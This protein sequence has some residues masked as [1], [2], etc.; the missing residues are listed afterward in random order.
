MRPN[1]LAF[2]IQLVQQNQ[3]ASPIEGGLD[4]N[5]A[6][7]INEVD[8]PKAPTPTDVGTL[9][10][11]I[12]RMAIGMDET[13]KSAY[14]KL[15]LDSEE[16]KGI[17]SYIESMF[18]KDFLDERIKDN[19]QDIDLNMARIKRFD[20][21]AGPV[22]LLGKT[23]QYLEEDLPMIL[24]S[25]F[26]LLGTTLASAAVGTMMAP[27]VGTV[28]GLAVGAAGMAASRYVESLAEAGGAYQEAFGKFKAMK[29][30]GHPDFVN[31]SEDEM[32]QKAMTASD[33]VFKDN[34]KLMAMDVPMLLLA[35]API[36]KVAAR[37]TG[38]GRGTY[39][40]NSIGAQIA[41]KSAYMAARYP[42]INALR[43]L[44]ISTG[45][46]AEEGVQ[47]GIT[48]SAIAK[49]TGSRAMKLDEMF[50][51]E[52][53]VKSLIGGF[54]VGG[55][56]SGIGTLGGKIKEAMIGKEDN[57]AAFDIN[58]LK[59]VQED[60]NDAQLLSMYNFW[61]R[62]KVSSMWGTLQAT[63]ER[64]QF[65]DKKAVDQ[66]AETKYHVERIKTLK[67]N[68]DE[69]MT[70]YQATIDAFPSLQKDIETTDPTTG[71]KINK[72]N[73]LRKQVFLLTAKLHGIETDLKEVSKSAIKNNDYVAFYTDM[74]K[75][76]TAV[77]QKMIN[78]EDVSKELEILEKAETKFLENGLQLKE[79]AKASPSGAAQTEV[80]P[81][82]QMA[83][84]PMPEE[85]TEKIDKT[86]ETVPGTDKTDPLYNEEVHKLLAQAG[87][88]EEPASETE[89]EKE[90][91]RL[92]KIKNTSKELAEELNVNQTS[93]LDS[94]GQAY[95]LNDDDVTPQVALSGDPD[96]TITEIN[97]RNL[98]PIK[99]NDGDNV[100][101]SDYTGEFMPEN[102]KGDSI[103]IKNGVLYQPDGEFQTDSYAGRQ[104]R[105]KTV[106][107]KEF[108][109]KDGNRYMVGFQTPYSSK[110]KNKGRTMQGSGY[111]I[112]VK[113][114]GSI[115][116]DNV[117]MMYRTIDE[118]SA[119]DNFL[120]YSAWPKL[121]DKLG[122]TPVEDT[123][124][125]KAIKEDATKKQSTDVKDNEK[126]NEE[127]GQVL[128][129]PEAKVDSKESAE[130][131]EK[132]RKVK[133]PELDLKVE[134][135]GSYKV[136]PKDDSSFDLVGP[137]GLVKNYKKRGAA[138][139]AAD[140]LNKTQIKK[141][142]GVAKTPETKKEE[143]KKEEPKKEE[144]SDFV[145]EFNK[146]EASQKHGILSREISLKGGKMKGVIR[147]T[148]GQFN[149]WGMNFGTLSKVNAYFKTNGR[150]P[151]VLNHGNGFIEKG[152][153]LKIE[154]LQN[155]DGSF[156]NIPEGWEYRLQADGTYNLYDGKRI[157]I[158][159][160]D[161][162]GNTQFKAGVHNSY[163]VEL[164]DGRFVNLVPE[165]YSELTKDDD[166]AEVEL[167][168]SFPHKGDPNVVTV[169][170]TDVFLYGNALYM[171][172]IDV[173][174]DG[175]KVSRVF[176]SEKIE[177]SQR[178]DAEAEKNK[179][180]DWLNRNIDMLANIRKTVAKDALLGI[181]LGIAEVVLKAFRVIY[182]K[183]N[184]QERFSPNVGD[185][186]YKKMGYIGKEDSSI[187]LNVNDP[188][189]IQQFVNA[190]NRFKEMQKGVV[191]N[192]PEIVH[193][194][195]ANSGSEAE[196][197]DA[198]TKRMK[199]AQRP[200][201]AEE[202][203][204]Y[205]VL[206][207]EKPVK[208]RIND[209]AKEKV[210]ENLTK[211]EADAALKAWLGK[212]NAWIESV[213][214]R[215]KETLQSQKGAGGLLKTLNTEEAFL[216]E[217]YE[218]LDNEAKLRKFQIENNM[219][220]LA[221]RV[222]VFFKIPGVHES[223]VREELSDYAKKMPSER[224]SPDKFKEYYTSDKAELS[225]D[226]KNY[227][228]SM[229]LPARYYVSLHA[230]LQSWNKEEFIYMTT[231]DSSV[232]L[233]SLVGN[234]LSKQSVVKK[235]LI[236][237]LKE[238]VENA[239]LNKE[240]KEQTRFEDWNAMLKRNKEMAS[241]ARVIMAKKIS[242]VP[243]VKEI[244]APY[245][246]AD[247]S[248]NGLV[249]S[250]YTKVQKEAMNI[251]ASMSQESIT[252]I[253]NQYKAY[254]EALSLIN[255]DLNV[256]RSIMK[257]MM[258]N[259]MKYFEIHTG[260]SK[261]ELMASAVSAHNSLKNGK[262]AKE[263]IITIDNTVDPV[264]ESSLVFL[265]Q[266]DKSRD[267]SIFL[268]RAVQDYN[269]TK[270]K[271]E[272]LPGY[273][274]YLLTEKGRKSAYSNFSVSLVSKVATGVT[275][276]E[277]MILAERF[278][279]VNGTKA[280]G[281]KLDNLFRR[282]SKLVPG[283]SS[284][285]KFSKNGFVQ[286]HK[287]KAPVV[288]W[289]DGLRYYDETKGLGNFT[290]EEL[291][292]TFVSMYLNR[293]TDSGIYLHPI[294]ILGDRTNQMA[295]VET[296]SYSLATAKEIAGPDVEREWKKSKDEIMR[297]LNSNAH[298]LN[299]P[300]D[301]ML[302]QIAEEFFYNYAV[303]KMD[304]DAVYQGDQSI[305]KGYPNKTK[306]A[307]QKASTG[308]NPVLNITDGMPTTSR[309]L[310]L[311]D[312]AGTY[313][314]L[315]KEYSVSEVAN[316]T[317]YISERYNKQI[318]VST[319]DLFHFDGTVK[320][321]INEY[322]P[323]SGNALL[324]KSN[325]I[326]L[327][328]E[329]VE[330]AGGDKSPLAAIYKQLNDPK[331]PIDLISFTSNAKVR[332]TSKDLT[333][334]DLNGPKVTNAVHNVDSSGIIFQQDLRF[335]QDPS[336][337][338]FQ[339]G[340]FP[341]QVYRY[342]MQFP[343]FE[344]MHNAFLQQQYEGFAQASKEILAAR[345]VP[346]LFIHFVLKQLKNSPEDM[347]IR[348]VL[349]SSENITP[350]VELNLE[351]DTLEDI[352]A[353][354]STSFVSKRDFAIGEKI[355]LKNSEFE[356]LT[357]ALGVLVEIVDS[358]KTSD[359]KTDYSV[360]VIDNL[361]TR[362]SRG[363]N[364][365]KFN[366]PVVRDRMMGL[367]G[368][369]VANKAVQRKVNR[370]AL[371][372]VSS[373]GIIG[374]KSLK[375]ARIETI[376]GKKVL[377]PGQALVPEKL[378]N[379]LIEKNGKKYLFIIR[380]PTTEMHSVSLV[381]VVGFLPNAMHNSIITD[382]A[383]QIKAGSDN[384]GDQRFAI[385][386][387]KGKKLTT[388]QENSNLVVESMLQIF[389]NPN[390]R[391]SLDTPIDLE[392][393]KAMADK[394]NPSKED[395]LNQNNVLSAIKMW[396]NNA[397]A[398]KA[399]GIA[400]RTLG[401]YQLLKKWDA[402]VKS[403]ISVNGVWLKSFKQANP[404]IQ[405]EI[406]SELANIT[407]IIVDNAKETK[408]RQIGLSQTTTNMY[409]AL[410]ML[411]MPADQL[412]YL[413]TQTE[414]GKQLFS[415]LQESKNILKEGSQYSVFKSIL[416]KYAVEG[417]DF[418]NMSIAKISKSS[419]SEQVALLKFAF[420]LSNEMYRY[421]EMMKVNEDGILNETDYINAISV[422]SKLKK[423][424]FDEKSRDLIL[425]KNDQHPIVSNLM[426]PFR[427]ALDAAHKTYSQSIYDTAPANML[428]DLMVNKYGYTDTKKVLRTFNRVAISTAFGIT[429]KNSMS[430]VE[431]SKFYDQHILDTP[432]SEYLKFNGKIEL[433]PGISIVDISDAQISDMANLIS[434]LPENVQEALLK[435]HI[436]EYGFSF[437]AGFTKAFP[438][439]LQNQ[440]ALKMSELQ[441]AWKQVD[442]RTSLSVIKEIARIIPD[443]IGM[444]IKDEEKL[445]T[446]ISKQV[447]L[448]K[449]PLVLIS[450]NKSIYV[451]KQ[452]VLGKAVT[453]ELISRNKKGDTFVSGVENRRKERPEF[454]RLP[455]YN[456]NAKTMTFAG[457]G[458]RQ[459]PQSMKPLVDKAIAMIKES[460][461]Y[462]LR[463][464]GAIGADTIFENAWGSDKKEIFLTKNY[465]EKTNPREFAIM[466]EI[467]PK[468]QSL[469][470][471]GPAKQ[472]RNTNQIFGAKLDTPVDFVLCWTQDGAVNADQTTTVTGGTGQAI[473]MASMKGIPVI[474]MLNPSWMIELE[475]VLSNRFIAQP[476]ANVK[477]QAELDAEKVIGLVS[478]DNRSFGRLK[479]KMMIFPSDDFYVGKGI[480][481]SK[482]GELY[483][484]AKASISIFNGNPPSPNSLLNMG[485]ESLE[486]FL[487]AEPRAKAAI[488]SKSDLPIYKVVRRGSIGTS[489]PEQMETPVKKAPITDGFKIYSSLINELEMVP[490]QEEKFFVWNG[491][492]F[493]QKNKYDII[494]VVPFGK[495]GI[496]IITGKESYGA[497]DP[498]TGTVLAS[499]KNLKALVDEVFDRYFES[500]DQ[501]N[502][503][504]LKLKEIRESNSGLS[505]KFQWKDGGLKYQ[506]DT[507]QEARAI[508][509]SAFQDYV[510]ETLQ[511][512]FPDVQYFESSE[513]FQAFLDKHF[514]GE[515][516]D[517]TK[518]GAAIES[519]AVYVNPKTAVQST[520]TH[521]YGHIYFDMLPEG[522][523][524]KA[525]R[526]MFVNENNEFDEEAFVTLLGQKAI[527][528]LRE[529]YNGKST[530]KELIDLLKDFWS[531]IKIRMNRANKSD[532]INL[533]SRKM[534]RGK[535]KA[536]AKKS[537]TLKYMTGN[538][539]V[540]DIN[541]Q[542]IELNRS[543]NNGMP[544]T[545]TIVIDDKKALDNFEAFWGNNLEI[546]HLGIKTKKR[547]EGGKVITSYVVP[548]T[549]KMAAYKHN[550]N[551]PM[552]GATRIMQAYNASKF[553]VDPAI[554]GDENIVGTVEWKNKH[555]GTPLHA[556]I[557]TA[558]FTQDF[559]ESYAAAV[560]EGLT[561]I[562]KDV[563]KKNIFDPIM[564][565][566]QEIEQNGG[567]VWSEMSIGND[568]LRGYGK[569]D[570][571]T[572]FPDSTV[573]IT[574]YKS[575]E[576]SIYDASGEFSSEYT[577]SVN[578][579]A[580][581]KEKHDAQLDIYTYLMGMEDS[582][583]SGIDVQETEIKPILFT[584]KGDTITDIK[585]EKPVIKKVTVQTVNN[586]AEIVKG[587]NDMMRD[588]FNVDMAEV[589]EM[590]LEE[591]AAEYGINYT[592]KDA[593]VKE[594]S[595]QLRSANSSKSMPKAERDQLRKKWKALDALLK[596]IRSRYKNVYLTDLEEIK[597]LL[598]SEDIGG[599]S[600][601][602]LVEIYNKLVKFQSIAKNTQ[603]G[604]LIGMIQKAIVAK[605]INDFNIDNPDAKIKEEED[606]TKKDVLLLAP[607]QMK[608]TQ[609]LLRLLV[610]T[611][612]E[613][614][615]KAQ[616]NMRESFKELDK[617]DKKLREEWDANN[618]DFWT[619]AK[620]RF[621]KMGG[622]RYYENMWDKDNPGFYK[623]VDDPSL[624]A[625]EKEYLQFIESYKSRPDIYSR[626]S[627]AK[628][629]LR[630]ANGGILISPN[631][632]EIYS[633]LGFFQALSNFVK[634]NQPIESIMM[635]ENNPVT[636]VKELV[637]YRDLISAIDSMK[638][639]NIIDK[640]RAAALVVAYTRKAK[641][642]L[643]S[644]YHDKAPG[645][646]AEKI[647]GMTYRK[648]TFIKNGKIVEQD[649]VDYQ[650]R[651]LDESM[652]LRSRF[653]Y[654]RGKKSAFS[655]DIYNSMQQFII[656][657]EYESALTNKNIDVN[658]ADMSVMDLA[659]I[660]QLSYQT[661]RDMPY[662]N[663]WLEHW[664]ERVIYGKN[665]RIS[666][667][668]N[669]REWIQLGMGLTHLTVMTFNPWLG[670]SN[671]IIGLINNVTFGGFHQYFVNSFQRWGKDFRKCMAI[672]KE[673]KIVNYKPEVP[674][675]S[676]LGF[677]AKAST[678]FI[679]LG[680]KIIQNSAFISKIPD[681]V[682]NN[683]QVDS[684]GDIQYIDPNGSKLTGD[685]IVK[686][687]IQ[688]SDIQ[689]RYGED[690]RR[691]YHNVAIWQLVMQFKTWLPDAINLIFAGNRQ[692][693]YGQKRVGIVPAMNLWLKYAFDSLTKGRAAA[694]ANYK[695]FGSLEQYK[696]AQRDAI[697]FILMATTLAFIVKSTD[698]DEEK[699]K[700][701]RKLRESGFYDAFGKTDTD[702]IADIL[703][704]FTGTINPKTLVGAAGLP[705]M[706]TVDKFA[707]LAE[708]M[709]FAT[710]YKQNSVYGEKGEYK[711]FDNALKV[712]PYKNLF[713][714]LTGAKNENYGKPRV[715]DSQSE[716]NNF[717]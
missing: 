115:D 448:N 44:A 19:Q 594:L 294:E 237:R 203:G 303:N 508:E 52:E 235:T 529:K 217:E 610:K 312:I 626:I 341:V 476:I 686:L 505:P 171:N 269:P 98:D 62:G 440:V 418:S 46:A 189:V 618:K 116:G 680:E 470:G 634:S 9:E 373:F 114:D 145:Q 125:S 423:I 653:F 163:R 315:D 104:R 139:N 334:E 135:K 267:A 543:I 541:K 530:F 204:K 246:S 51:N 295:F 113:K 387:Y 520:R 491:E 497:V 560:K 390:N 27:G 148:E 588:M 329:Y 14:E 353:D 42:G 215:T 255:D 43:A 549:L 78:G 61:E 393:P 579:S 39:M 220:S 355:L 658:G 231:S 498:I 268:A 16:N 623:S 464:G 620:R 563:L 292:T 207:N 222:R 310:V 3:P 332:D 186:I 708:S 609:P 711:V 510:R 70:K 556:F 45:E 576:K 364:Q 528:E 437:N 248:Y 366:H 89:Q 602:E 577:K 493:V 669:E 401:V 586:G 170:D 377:S 348:K 288:K 124:K 196:Y 674:D 555:V 181:P 338:E 454:D 414:V 1:P 391:K 427:M 54:A 193:W 638:K 488:D 468:P 450:R 671:L 13:Q 403:N 643:A 132:P 697:K 524:K 404:D 607:S 272:G 296:R 249:N 35:Y 455:Y 379:Q 593:E 345:S 551:E 517:L 641:S 682:W 194:Y 184:P 72:T 262:L 361:Y 480:Y 362:G 617:I 129:T 367:I 224:V 507:A 10:N 599:K 661:K 200:V 48:D 150:Y 613:A 307:S 583:R 389:F 408:M 672:L 356:K 64:G 714:T 97:N 335:D 273:L 138:I 704:Q 410:R 53:F 142:E 363:F 516:L 628:S 459:M 141:G 75:E 394:I 383:T 270:K 615:Q 212:Q 402:T 283:L 271:G 587:F 167:A 380:V 225:S 369:Y 289:M 691:N 701:R 358:T 223:N 629:T 676:M 441:S 87:I 81:I 291:L 188:M 644:G 127:R 6:A 504:G 539:S 106:P 553:V 395:S 105:N 378:K 308:I 285:P 88:T 250:F 684:N 565:E 266:G 123:A 172:R 131:A 154:E 155:A 133:Q 635:Y 229:D 457:I 388:R 323:V 112:P 526:K 398:K 487:K 419:P 241:K 107:L 247:I 201:I 604:S 624:T 57:L 347:F 608:T 695:E 2:A 501:Q 662:A 535:K 430:K 344:Q 183:L 242:G 531:V 421:S 339:E 251:N 256:A 219:H 656:E 382:L 121:R 538:K 236:Q 601:T 322:N 33:D 688:N 84:A 386:T 692:D 384:D 537:G 627:K 611:Q 417:Q 365:S 494:E 65:N 244:L 545:G 26:G 514:P 276:G 28:A 657:M 208:Y 509:D 696:K 240:E 337:M 444:L 381:E 502:E 232:G 30:A 371:Q 673:H 573:R 596:K 415:E 712:L 213:I 206:L 92:T 56:M 513:N 297:V 41:E 101:S 102:W 533:M 590:T 396:D 399:L 176:G 326:V 595:K 568:S 343:E 698:D 481:K 433:A 447:D 119:G 519:A 99:E 424:G 50:Q 49:Q 202:N 670:M 503:L 351:Y 333:I 230:Y 681:N 506:E 340:E 557:E 111:L 254:V 368:S 311:K 29:D 532:V 546:D 31:M 137:E 413:F 452:S 372:E 79:P 572:I 328:K 158:S 301:H 302:E 32:K 536:N 304:V 199:Q 22:T 47:F 690:D 314:L 354:E 453:Y 359:G 432:L 612:L 260:L 4:L 173:I 55:V 660:A 216:G 678:F 467:H 134:Q 305:Y 118:K 174:K 689:G 606:L 71:K 575:S 636:G 580:S 175:K 76:L 639:S 331:N 180:M 428:I 205:S 169:H 37:A 253:E 300:N 277:E 622:H 434:A 640:I 431:A 161:P 151:T 668:Q 654:G 110:A 60:A 675:G 651:T 461:K 412:T 486:D 585:F 143:V 319:G 490:G 471:E 66:E 17:G 512:L 425:F 34:M 63:A 149:Y 160:I 655:M 342:M 540:D 265:G 446:R 280:D 318:A 159:R 458:S 349:L 652:E 82:E 554:A 74:Q 685:E 177:A 20:E 109:D 316:G 571:I 496:Y 473:R 192:T 120:T 11:F 435:Y 667:H 659:N 275:T 197:L 227:L 478:I 73:P 472:A 631:T 198:W 59:K 407:N 309:M 420:D 409:Y 91:N 136:N 90:S 178:T 94:K 492:K 597:K 287:S 284:M 642:L 683:M 263:R 542:I 261:E 650:K 108:T 645:T 324:M 370:F 469:K 589:T 702:A 96:K 279:S 290:G 15:N 710:T 581:K 511:S 466:R 625:T 226:I 23:A 258:D 209:R 474:N 257:E 187:S 713:I 550:A 521:E 80:S 663:E 190:F 523:I 562:D 515:Q 122:L 439:N 716:F 485:Y 715:S 317:T 274:D 12:N 445:D 38:V 705:A 462:T 95:L 21:K 264:I 25:S 578:G 7:A 518:L 140:K 400:A 405:A 451:A 325:W 569:L 321:Q 411:G 233:K 179:V 699:R 234:T 495:H 306:R 210:A 100:K 93:M 522:R 195:E 499:N 548:Y 646:I 475:A 564:K 664:V 86:E 228:R 191:I 574:D 239:Y 185:I 282:L 489:T 385:S 259:E 68:A 527:E 103:K 374:S 147:L 707:E 567:K 633:R 449:D 238:F 157:V 632:F 278:T 83:G 375:S 552:V 5:P 647:G 479:S 500:E 463:S 558:T 221:N 146:A 559:E 153:T 243:K 465:T 166:G 426:I 327:T 456:S 477:T 525:I 619:K 591:F 392:K 679:T 130:P 616:D 649:V 211:K 168:L 665:P 693:V 483:Q 281:A 561:K 614:S 694:N 600:Y 582:D 598:G 360:K 286:L 128:K 584:L 164:S 637:S 117:V 85:K 330:L 126:G 566:I 67:K 687:K 165:Q 397:D 442:L 350:D 320:G 443:E 162:K 24:G 299:L 630:E 422:M 298:A 346:E 245:V 666:L 677:F 416:E 336:K 700:R 547:T 352:S 709:L 460:G 8:I 152:R 182:K 218:G 717:E 570:R 592:E 214:E 156:Q 69:M 706:N 429:E 436:G 544:F 648:G 603:L 144:V 58:K 357:N 40:A 376:D 703:K 18:G 313:Q 36:A 438:I 293:K 482:N 534:L 621:S 484:I 77:G 406:N 252:Y 605:Q